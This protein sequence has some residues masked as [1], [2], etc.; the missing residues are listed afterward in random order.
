MDDLTRGR[1]ILLVTPN[2]ENNSL[3][4]TYCLWLLARHLGWSVRTVGVRGRTLW[5]PVAE[6]AF[7][8]SCH[9]LSDLD[10]EGRRRGLAEAAEWADVVIA[11]KPLPSSLGIAI[12]VARQ[13]S[14]P[15]VVDIDDP[16]IE[17][18]LRWQP[19]RRRVKQRL[20]GVR[21]DLLRLKDAAATLPT[22]VSNPVLQQTYGGIVIPHVRPLPPTPTYRDGADIIVRFVGTLQDHMGIDLLRESV[23]R[24]HGRGVTLELTGPAPRDAAPWERWLGRTSLAEGHDLVASADV[25]V[26][27]SRPRSWSLGQLPAKLVDAMILG[28]P[29]IASDLAPIRWALGGTGLL[30]PPDDV[31][32]LFAALQSLRNPERR[33]ALGTEAHR[34]ALELFTVEAVAPAF[35]D[36]IERAIGRDASEQPRQ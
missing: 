12:P 8:E 24:F 30:V 29:V 18:R 1:H 15:L 19:F 28:R 2:F 26:L 20:T 7:A 13:S 16:D 4:R 34:R 21:S 3:G 10:D 25:V 27:P 33:R 11:V 35:R 22:M 31:D 23:A 36:Q 9:V 6:G 17:Y 5:S 32:A 14:R